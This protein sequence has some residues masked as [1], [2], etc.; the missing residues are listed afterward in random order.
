LL[1]LLS[2][3]SSSSVLITKYNHGDEIEKNQMGG[4]C[5]TYG[6]KERSLQDFGGVTWGRRPF[7]RPR[8]RW[9]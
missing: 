2:S 3:S 8:R 4:A 9:G 5:G 1:L 7:G 6:G